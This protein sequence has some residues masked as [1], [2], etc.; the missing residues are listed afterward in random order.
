MSIVNY[1][2]FQPR[3]ESSSVVDQKVHGMVTYIRKQGEGEAGGNT[4]GCV[5][6]LTN[7]C[8]V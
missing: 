1:Q 8:K 2:M 3:L 6:M 4:G 5:V 7:K